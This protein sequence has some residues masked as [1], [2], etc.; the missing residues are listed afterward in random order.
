MARRAKIEPDPWQAQ[1]LH[2]TAWQV[3]LNITRQGGKSTTTAL[4]ALYELLYKFPA[5]IL[6]LSPT[7]RQSDELFLKIKSFYQELAGEIKLSATT[8]VIPADANYSPGWQ[9]EKQT[10]RE[11][12][13]EN[14]NRVVA[15]PSK[16]ANIRGFSGVTLLI[17]D[18]ASRVPD[19]LY[20][21]IRPM[22]AVSKGR[23]ML[24]STPWGKRGHFFEAWENGG[25][26]WERYEVPATLCPRISP[27]FLAYEKA[28]T[29]PLVYNQEFMCQFSETEDSV[30][31]YD[32][33]QAMFEG[34][35]PMALFG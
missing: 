26:E 25:P 32:E 17:E 35:G 30:F 27:E 23:L 9:L 33:I 19:P 24:L 6:I 34:A 18:E 15:L 7:Q 16:E 21:A 22:L 11:L 8:S 31:D 5:L 13:L 20:Q 28:H 1:L 14:G 2:S 12:R 3:M 10:G 4:V 29:P